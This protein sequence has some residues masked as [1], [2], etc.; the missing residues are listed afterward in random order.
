MPGVEFSPSYQIAERLLM[1][2]ATR[3]FRLL[4]ELSVP[5]TASA[6][7]STIDSASDTPEII[8]KLADNA[9]YSAKRAKR[10][11]VMSEAA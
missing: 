7:L 5:I 10:N 2:L 8:F 11:R 9:L 4:P 1:R 6:G 3:L